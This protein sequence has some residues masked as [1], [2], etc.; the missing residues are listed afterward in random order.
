MK[1]L[2]RLLLFVFCNLFTILAMS[3]TVFAVD[4]LYLC[5][6]VKEVNANV[7]MVRVH[8]ISEGCVGEKTFKVTRSQQLDKFVVG[9]DICFMIDMNKCPQN[10]E[11]TILAE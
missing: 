7:R 4:E 2:S 3:E 6:V 8:V 5:G 11:A 10:Q 9:E 1:L